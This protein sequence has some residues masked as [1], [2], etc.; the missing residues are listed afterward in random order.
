MKTPC[1]AKCKNN[2]GICI[3]CFRTMAEIGEWRHMSDKQHSSKIDQIK[4]IRSTHS[5]SQCGKPAYCDI[6]AGKSTCWCFEL[7]KRNTSAI[8]PGTCL[9]RTCLSALPLLD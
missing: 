5:C 6:S 4:G 1:I 9:C 8:K 3:G 2:E 7:S